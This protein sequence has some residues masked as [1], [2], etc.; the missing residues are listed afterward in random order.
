MGREPYCKGGHLELLSHSNFLV[1]S[2]LL[3]LRGKRL[4]SPPTDVKRNRGGD[5]T[6]ILI[7]F[8]Q[9]PSNIRDNEDN[10]RTHVTQT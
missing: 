2:I 6:K 9:L 5:V 7:Q 3:S 1:V 8:L 4:N 10:C